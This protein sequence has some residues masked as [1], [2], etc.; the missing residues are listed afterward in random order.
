VSDLVVRL[1]GRP[2]IERRGVLLP[3]PRGRK[4]WAVMAY[5]LLAER[6]VPRARLA[7]LVFGGADD[8]LGALRWT[9]TQVRR[10]LAL[11]TALRGDPLGFELPEDTKVD[12]LALNAGETDPT[13][14]RGELL[15]GTD[16]GVGG[17]FDAW[18]LVER[19]RLAGLCEGVLRDAALGKLAVGLPLEGAAFASRALS[20]SEFDESLHELLVR[21]LARAGQLGAA[22]HQANA[23]EVL[24]RRELGRAPDPRV[25]RAAEQSDAGGSPATGDRAAAVGQLQAG[26]TALG[27]GAAEPGVACLRMACA[28]ARGHGDAGLLARTLVELGAALVHAVRGRD[29]EGAAVL[30]EALAVAERA[31]DRA[32]AGRACREL[33]YVEVQAGRGASAG[34]WLERATALAFTDGERAAV[35]GVRGMALSDRAHYGPAVALLS[36]SV[37]TAE[38]CGAVRQAAWSSALLGRALLIRGDLAGAAAA[39]DRSLALVEREG[40]VAFLPL[41]ESLRAEVALRSGDLERSDVLLEHAFSLGCRLGDPCWE[42]LAARAIGLVH[43]AR[44]ELTMALERLRDAVRRAVRVSDPYVWVHAYSL[45]ALAAVAIRAETDEAA[46]VVDD[47]ERIAARSDMREL[48]VRAAVHRAH[49]GNRAGIEAARPLAETI[50]SDALHAA[51]RAIT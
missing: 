50:D 22:R 6:K 18:L 9:L 27:A 44:G 43:E 34:R 24:F 29:E 15:E 11:P 37:A 33:G 51:L 21:C 8:P 20:L 23:C 30:H 42:A 12:V 35:L 3:P 36:E 14:V 5:L 25:R 2:E 19:R 28:E 32:V 45:D 40:W 7:A 48:I 49:L 13:L 38:R 4:V 46:Q 31:G 47:L 16:P 39:L 1:L 26:L 17:A 10:S 41:P